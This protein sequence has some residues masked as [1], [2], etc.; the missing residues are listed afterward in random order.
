MT[1]ADVVIVGGG[2][3]G[4]CTA[5]ALA[6]GHRKIVI[7]EALGGSAATFRGELLHPRAAE[8]LSRLGLLQPLLREGAM[9]V[10]GFAV[11]LDAE[12][13]IP[14][15]Y[16]EISG[17]GAPGLVMS[18]PE[19]VRCL[20]REV[21]GRDGVELRMGARV[22]E[23][24]REHGVVVG[25]RLATGEEL[26]AP[27]TIVSDGRHSKLRNVVGAAEETRLLSF[28][29]A[30]LTEPVEL[31][32]E[33]YGHVFLGAWGPILAYAVAGGRA[34]VCIDLP[35]D[36]DK[37][38]HA[39]LDFVRSDCAPATPEPLRGA[40]LRALAERPAELCATHVIKT[41]RCTAPGVALVGDS[42]G[43]AHPLTAGGMTIALNDVSTLAEELDRAPS[44]PAA[45]LRYQERRYEFVRAREL[46][47]DVLY[48]LFRR[49]DGGARALRRGLS[50]YWRSG[51]R[52]RSASL[53]LLSGR[54]S[55]STFFLG[56]YLA[57]VGASAR[58]V[59][60]GR[61]AAGLACDRRTAATGLARTTL[62]QL[63]Q[64]AKTL[65]LDHSR[66]PRSLRVR[67]SSLTTKRR[68]DEASAS[69][70]GGP[71]SQPAKRRT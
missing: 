56:E 33:R 48:D 66:R 34:R 17:A 46:L 70:D 64:T 67:G 14:L 45:L 2:F 54:E 6:D 39:V 47:V 26:R 28:T 44:I 43:C 8:A 25:V 42:G 71:I 23:L 27:L 36:I 18:H 19:M 7:L 12:R 29:A 24:L 58:D 65:Y 51:M 10:E 11:A 16:A 21:A 68:R 35:L 63:K 5:R 4:M 60:G 37:G 41:R 13:P 40:I 20:R 1:V 52:A 3:S 15:A 31:P 62:D 38:Q 30:F 32:F 49:D 61:D 57:V 22:T 59:L 53:S 55:R 50:R 69:P 9:A